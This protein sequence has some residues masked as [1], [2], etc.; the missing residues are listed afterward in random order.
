MYWKGN[1]THSLLYAGWKACTR[2][3]VTIICS[4][5]GI[6]VVT[7]WKTPYYFFLLNT[8]IVRNP[9]VDYISSQLRRKAQVLRLSYLFPQPHR[10]AT[11]LGFYHALPLTTLPRAQLFTFNLSLELQSSAKPNNTPCFETRHSNAV[12]ARMPS[13]ARTHVHVRTLFGINL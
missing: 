5:V 1:D 13:S 4:T 9:N 7:V 11:C 6:S 2:R 8:D 12:P 3:C 10:L